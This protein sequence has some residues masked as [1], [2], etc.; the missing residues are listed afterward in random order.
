[1][2]HRQGAFIRNPAVAVR[3]AR[4]ACRQLRRR[5]HLDRRITVLRSVIHGLNHRCGVLFKA[6]DQIRIVHIC[7]ALGIP[8]AGQRHF[9]PAVVGQSGVIYRYAVHHRRPVAV[10][11]TVGDIVAGHGA[12]PVGM[13]VPVARG[14]PVGVLHR[15]GGIEAVDLAVFR[16]FGFHHLALQTCVRVL[17]RHRLRTL[18]NALD[19]Q[20]LCVVGEVR[21]IP[22]TYRHQQVV[23]C[24]DS[25]RAGQVDLA[26]CAARQIHAARTGHVARRR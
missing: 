10:D 19:P 1:M 5:F 2:D 24:R 17:R 7:I 21:L 16:A 15:A 9:P 20:Y 25:R 14:H 18:G 11:H 6:L 3:P 13:A 22:D 12:G 23:G 8:V 26:A 4:E